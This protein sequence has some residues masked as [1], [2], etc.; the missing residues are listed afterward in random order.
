MHAGYMNCHKRTGLF[1]K[2][3]LI[4]NCMRVTWHGSWQCLSQV[5]KWCLHWAFFERC[6]S[7]GDAVERKSDRQPIKE[8]IYY[9]APPKRSDSFVLHGANNWKI[10]CKTR[11]ST[12]KYFQTQITFACIKFLHS[13]NLA[14]VPY[15]NN[16]LIRKRELMWYSL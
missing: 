3:N 11:P 10:K 7:Y 2:C 13:Y 5:T 1:W 8:D 9:R 12:G 4:R 6:G 14:V 15:K 16:Q